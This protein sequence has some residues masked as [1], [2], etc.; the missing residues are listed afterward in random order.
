[1]IWILLIILISSNYAYVDDLSCNNYLLDY[2][3]HNILNYVND[4][5]LTFI[6]PTIGRDTLIDTVRS[7]LY[8]TNDQWKA[9]VIFD[10]IEPTLVSIDKRISIIKSDNKLGEHVNSAGSVRN[11]G[12]QFATTEWIAFV[13]DD[14]SISNDYVDIFYWEIETSKSYIELLLFRMLDDGQVKPNL[15]LDGDLK[16][17]DVGI[18]FAVKKTKFDQGLV[19]NASP[20]E[21]FN[22]LS[23]CVKAGYVLILSPYVTYY[24]RQYKLVMASNENL[25]NRLVFRM[26]VMD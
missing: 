6:I 12:I 24:V 23:N 16:L 15:N 8:Q 3:N 20:V 2:C 21:D 19:F 13:D 7:L 18:S 17:Q 22:F 11:Y 25:G 1:M 9:I 14:D 4:V 26:Q 5:K 10:G